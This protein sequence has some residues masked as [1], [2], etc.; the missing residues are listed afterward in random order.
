MVHGA[1]PSCNY[2]NQS[3]VIKIKTA[4]LRGW[5]SDFVLLG[6]EAR[7]PTRSFMEDSSAESE[8][9]IARIQQ[10]EHERDELR[11]DI[12]QLCM[13]Q[14]GPSYLLVATRLH[15]QRTAG[16]EQEIENLKKKLAASTRENLNLKEELSEAY[17]IKSQLAE[18]HNESVS[19]NLELEKQLKFFQGCVASAFAERDHALMEAEKFKD[20]AEVMSHKLND[21]QKRLEELNSDAIRSQE[22]LPRL[23]ADLSKQGKEIEIFKKVVNKFYEIRQQTSVGIEDEDS[24]WDDKCACLLDDPADT[25]SFNAHSEDSTA[26]YISALQEQLETLRSSV[27]NLQN[28]LRVGLEIENHLK[29][30]VSK[31]ERKRIIS[32]KLIMSGISR[33]REYHSHQRLHILDL[34][35]EGKSYLKSI[36]DVL[37]EKLGPLNLSR[38]EIFVLPFSDGKPDGKYCGDE[39]QST[40]P[41][42]AA[43]IFLQRNGSSLSNVFKEVDTSEVLSQALH[44]KVSALLLLQQE[45]ERHFLERNVNAAR[46]KKLD[47]LQR[48]LLQVTNEKVKALMELAQLKQEFQLLQEKITRGNGQGELL[49][50]QRERRVTV[51]GKEGKFKNLWKNKYLKRWIG[52]VEFDGSEAD[53]ASSS[54]GYFTNRRASYSMDVA[55]MKIEHATLKESMESMEHLTSVVRKLRLS[56]LKAKEAFTSEDAVISS[57]TL[58]DITS[59]AKLVKTA[60]GSSLPLSWSGEEGIGPYGNGIVEETSN[61]EDPSIEKID[62]VSAAGFEMVELLTLAAQILKDKIARREVRDGS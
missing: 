8:S 4:S 27:D 53:S 26:K 47:E 10:L 52:N 50:S 33:L 32:D 60:L 14:A 34:L 62:S 54:D 29:R 18:L 12:E 23:Q 44:E 15:F 42:V 30:Q 49:P 40:D 28:K 58:D 35:N 37:Q 55:R 39:R 9:S 11:K 20:R 25:W 43:E 51:I 2:T 3:S 45:E 1:N 24:G 59:E 31:L 38:E 6:A 41:V 61:Y 7:N 16:L 56:L 13:Q 48:S 21:S 22:L 17:R 19:K 46:L 5:C 36:I 57:K